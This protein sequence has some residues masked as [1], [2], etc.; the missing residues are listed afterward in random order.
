VV[1]PTVESGFRCFKPFWVGFDPFSA[2]ASSGWQPATYNREKDS[3]GLNIA[4]ASNTAFSDVQ[5]TRLL[6]RRY[7][8]LSPERSTPEY[9]RG[10]LG[11]RS[12]R[13]ALHSH[14]PAFQ[15]GKPT[16]YTTV[17]LIQTAV[18]SVVNRR[19]TRA[20]LPPQMNGANAQKRVILGFSRA[21]KG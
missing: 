4:R 17:Q 9:Q 11:R 3:E 6:F 19:A 1:Q 2:S 16:P 20:Q 13:S 10:V 8:R 12:C 15:A 7:H 5:R 18:A 14:N 21:G